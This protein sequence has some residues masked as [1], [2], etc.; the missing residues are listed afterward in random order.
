MVGHL[1]RGLAH[2]AEIVKRDLGKDVKDIPGAGAAGGLGA[3]LVAFLDA[4]LRPGTEIIF[5]ALG[6]DRALEGADLLFT[7]EGRI[8]GQDLFGKAPME[9]AKRA[10]AYGIPS[11][12]I[13]G[14]T[15]KD[16]R[17]VFEHGLDAVIGTINRPMNLE[18][19]VQES[20]RLITDAAMRACRMVQV[21][22]SLERRT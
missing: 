16:Y 4:K 17:V 6:V 11:I 22:M 18:R 10:R 15:G 9:V 2:Y 13:A 21:G 5:E 12:A 1:E 20:S 3:G 19:A 7:G 8:D 14:S